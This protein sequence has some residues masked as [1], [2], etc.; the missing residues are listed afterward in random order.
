MQAR[1]EPLHLMACHTAGDMRVEPQH[2]MTCYTAGDITQ[3][4]QP[5]NLMKWPLQVRAQGLL[6]RLLK[7]S[8]S[9]LKE[10]RGTASRCTCR[11]NVHHT[12]QC[13]HSCSSCIL[14]RASF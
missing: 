14:C 5:L 1:A 4:A 3:G 7:R 6:G 9:F 2:L 10:D 11:G 8:F 13:R 12:E